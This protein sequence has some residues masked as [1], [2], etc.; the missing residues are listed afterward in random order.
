MPFLRVSRVL[1]AS[2]GS[3]LAGDLAVSG[4][5]VLS[6]FPERQQP[7]GNFLSQP[8]Q[9]DGWG[10]AMWA[11][12]E[13]FRI[14]H[15]KDFGVHVFPAMVRGVDWLS[16]ARTRDPLHLIP[17][18]NVL[19]NEYVPGHLT[20]HNFLAK[21]NVTI[22]HLHTVFS[23]TPA[24]IVLHLP[25]FVTADSVIADGKPANV[26]GK[27]VHLN[28]SVREVRIVWRQLSHPKMNYERTVTSFEQEY[29]RRWTQFTTTG[30]P[31]EGLDSWQVPE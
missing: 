24:E 14:T 12:G 7:D 2:H 5:Q 31:S 19:D 9:Y 23:D 28:P 21:H 8:D 30:T 18:T 10:E 11:F 16:Q 27:G 3:R 15:D 17:A 22:L 20:G 6:F 1:R 25:W 13:H 4:G 29:R 26:D